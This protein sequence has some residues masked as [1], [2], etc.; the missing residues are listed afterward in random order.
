MN[1][2]PL[3]RCDQRRLIVSA[4]DLSH[5]AI[6][7]S[8]PFAQKN[9]LDANPD[10]GRMSGDDRRMTPSDTSTR[11]WRKRTFMAATS[12]IPTGSGR[13]RAAV[14]E[15]FG[16]PLVMRELKIRVACRG[17]IVVKTEVCGVCRA[18]LE[19]ARGVWLNP[20]A[21]PFIPGPR[22]RSASSLRLGPGVTGVK[23]GDRVGVPWALHTLWSM[24]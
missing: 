14:V 1:L 4:T 13:M 9:N 19:V 15:Q 11:G 23:E 16:L 24:Q 6:W 7:H 20:P 12:Y 18:D 21:L 5:C 17:Q 10:G 2:R 8:F 3:S 22:G